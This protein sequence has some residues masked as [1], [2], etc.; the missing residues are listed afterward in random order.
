MLSR[1]LDT[2]RNHRSRYRQRGLVRIYLCRLDGRPGG[3]TSG[4]QVRFKE[5]PVGCIAL[6]LRDFRKR[7]LFSALRHCSGGWGFCFCIIGM[8][9]LRPSKDSI[10]K[11]HIG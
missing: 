2:R 5:S 8:E 1:E 3:Q 10:V 11:L 9:Q 4:Q 6:D 7:L